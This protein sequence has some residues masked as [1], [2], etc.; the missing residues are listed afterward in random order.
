MNTRTGNIHN[1]VVNPRIPFAFE[2]AQRLQTHLLMLVLS[3]A[4]VLASACAGGTLRQPLSGVLPV[5]APNAVRA[6]SQIEVIVGPVDVDNGTPIG[7]VMVGAYGPRAYSA[8][9]Q[10]GLAHFIIP[11]EHTL[12]PGYLALI[13]AAEEARG[14][15]SIVLVSTRSSSAKA[16][17]STNLIH[18]FLAPIR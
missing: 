14:E 18:E 15:T 13:F 9:F 11:S 4:L 3:L 2:A 5:A 8:V 7:M 16:S 1:G 17:T 12:Q 10:A 6:G